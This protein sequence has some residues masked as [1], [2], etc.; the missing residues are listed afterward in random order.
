MTLSH[1][2]TAWRMN[3]MK[4]SNMFSMPKGNSQ[5][6]GSFRY[7]DFKSWRYLSKQEKLPPFVIAHNFTM[8][9]VVVVIWLY[10]FLLFHHRFFL[11]A[12]LSIV[13][14]YNVIH[15]RQSKIYVGRLKNKSCCFFRVGCRSICFHHWY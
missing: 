14:L 4:I 7:V 12:R 5:I 2:H 10:G 9:C 3:Q 1:P 15:S 13:M 11:L 6:V 8:T